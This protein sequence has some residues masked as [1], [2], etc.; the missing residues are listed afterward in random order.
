[1]KLLKKIK[2]K[3][4]KFCKEGRYGGGMKK[5]LKDIFLNKIYFK[6][7]DKKMLVFFY[8]KKTH[9]RIIEVTNYIT[10]TTAVKKKIKKNKSFL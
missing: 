1:M 2:F 10:L 4:N 8:F 5:V 7:L 3:E 6:K 9:G